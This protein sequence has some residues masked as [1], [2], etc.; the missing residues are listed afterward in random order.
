MGP[1]T[2]PAGVV[3]LLLVLLLSRCLASPA[4]GAYATEEVRRG[5]LKVTVS[6]TGNLQP[7]V[8]VD[9]DRV[10]AARRRL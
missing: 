7:T 3:A 2:D 5:N 6:A 1:L 9:I 4:A 8:Q 10:R